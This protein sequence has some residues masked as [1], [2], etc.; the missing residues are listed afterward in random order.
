VGL[1]W[2]T[3]DTKDG[4]VSLATD[5]R[6][7]D[8][9]Y[10]DHEAIVK[11]YRSYDMEI[12][13]VESQRISTGMPTESAFAGDGA[14]KECHQAIYDQWLSTK[15][16]HAF[17]ILVR[18][19]REFDRDCTPCHTAG[20]HEIGGFMSAVDTPDL[21]NVQCES[22]HGNSAAHARTPIVKTP[23]NA[24]NVCT[25][26]HSEEQTPDFK[27]NTYWPKIAH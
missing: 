1:A 15:H 14:C 5:V 3:L 12:A 18:E 4:I 16:A 6:P 26:C 25:S 2:A 7:L 13:S 10:A 27:F 17:D 22:C 9:A 21:K 20:F 24:R 19:G 11:L 8:E 23:T